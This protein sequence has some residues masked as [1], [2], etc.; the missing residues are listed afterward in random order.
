MLNLLFLEWRDPRD[1]VKSIVVPV[2]RERLEVKPEERQ[3][4]KSD[5]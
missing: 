2:L 5:L 1:Q 4:K 3:T